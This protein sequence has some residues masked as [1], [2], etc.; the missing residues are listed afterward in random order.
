VT[1]QV[2]A[3][4]AGQHSFSIRTDNLE[5]SEPK[6]VSAELGSHGSRTIAWHARI[7]DKSTP[8][9]AVVLQDGSLSGHAELSGVER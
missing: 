3:S 1:L 2:V 7:V 4:G 5:I 6:V 8:W 9:V